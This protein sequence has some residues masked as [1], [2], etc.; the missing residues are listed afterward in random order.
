MKL[1]L[2]YTLGLFCLLLCSCQLQHLDV[3]NLTVEGRENFVGLQ[4]QQPR[5]SWKITAA[6]GKPITQTAYQIF[7]ASTKEGA[8][9]G[10]ATLWNSGKVTSDSSL[11]VLF[12]GQALASYAKV[13]WKVKVWTAQGDSAT[14]AVNEWSM[15]ILKKEEWKAKWI[16]LDTFS[17]GDAPRRQQTR[18]AARYL[19]KEVSISKTLSQATASISGLGLYELYI[20][21]EKIGDDVMSP[22]A[23]DYNHEVPYNTYNITK[24]LLKGNNAI[25]VVLGNGRFFNLRDFKGK[26][27]PVTGIPQINYGYPRMILQIRLVYTDGSIDY[28]QSDPS[29]KIT[30]QGPIRANNE[31][32][33]EEYDA[34]MELNGW[35]K[36]G[37]DDASWQQAAL[38]KPP[39]GKLY[40]QTNENIKIKQTLKPKSIYK[41]VKGTY[42][43]DMGQNMVGW[44]RIQVKG[45]T[46]DTVRMVFAERLKNKDT[47]YL[48][49]LRDA[50]VTDTYV[51][52]GST[53]EN[54]APRFT[55]HGFQ[56]IEVSGL[57]YQPTIADFQGEVVY[58]DVPTIGQF[59]TSDPTINQ[60][61]S[62]AY[63]SIRGNY[64]GIPTDC[65]QRDERVAWLG[66]R[67]MS[68]YGESFLFDNSRLYSKWMADT[69]SAQLAN[70]SLPDIVP[71]YW[72]NNSDNV[73]YPSAFI[74]IPEMLRKQFGDEKTYRSYYPY[75]KKWLMYMWK[76]HGKGDLV[77]KDSYGDWCVAPEEGTNTIWTNDP[78]RTTDGGLV[79]ASYYYYCLT[80]MENF[81]KL[82][83]LE[84]DLKQFAELK[85]RVYLAFNKKF[86]NATE[87]HYSNNTTTANLLPLTFG[88]VPAD[89]KQA[90]FQ[91]IVAR[92][93]A[94]G[95]HI[96]SGIMGMMW[97]MRGLSDHG[98]PDLAYKLATNTTYPSW[99]YM[100]ANGATT[101]W[102]LWNG[103][104]ADPL[105]N[106]WNHQMLL[107]DLLIWYYEY[108]AGIKSDPQATAFKKIIMNPIFPDSLKYVSAS[109]VSKY[110]TIKSHWSKDKE[111]FTWKI[112]VPPNSS[113]LVYLPA[114]D[115]RNVQEGDH[116]LASR[117]G[118]T[119][120]GQEK[121]CILIE[122]GSG[123]YDFTV[124][125]IDQK[126]TVTLY[127]KKL[128][129]KASYPELLLNESAHQLSPNGLAVTKANSLVKLN[130]YY[131]LASRL[132]RYH[133]RF[134]KDA[135]GI[136]QSDLGDFKATVD[137]PN[138]KIAIATN[139]ETATKADFLNA[140]HEYIVEI[141]R[142]YQESK[143]RIIDVNTGQSA[144][145]TATNDGPGGHGA[146]VVNKGFPVG[147][148]YDYYCFGL[149]SGTAM[150]V[151]ELEVLAKAADLH[152]LIYGDSITEPEGYFPTS[153]FPQSWTQLI[154]K[155][156][157]GKGISSGRGGT[158][159]RELLDRI[160]NELPYV[161]SKYVM[162]TIGTN[163][164][165]TAENL[166]ELVEYIQSQGSIP[167]LN[168][169][170]SNES[171][172][173]VA[174][175]AVIEKVRNKYKINGCKFDIATSVDKE[176]KQVD[177]STMW[178]EDYDFGKIYHHPN[179]K[180][181]LQM[182]NR[183][184]IDVPEIYK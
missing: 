90:V 40:A 140:A 59:N 46:G 127:H 34:R 51:L 53:K 113:A 66:D 122:I 181:S 159:I 37:Y 105:M 85:T 62:N 52:K 153:D 4:E 124:L 25:G 65:P 10:D 141:H 102:E 50:R 19:R 144:E 48:A 77:L 152:L 175:N 125:P 173:Q 145:I 68:S 80:L 147:R 12:K 128:N 28:I 8:E 101:I 121:G 33:G 169:I 126:P 182:Y 35:S 81:A 24:Q 3:Q 22:T 93:A 71:A 73:T 70:G 133:V 108:L 183:T 89:K 179:V 88:L 155:N 131:S 123:S 49:N 137:L 1:N 146:G 138:K 116:P 151:S 104:T 11:N 74:I 67:L 47:L 157:K 97:I 99:G 17:R 98:R 20:N 16:G 69:K 79:A 168:N 75:M 38:V 36:P 156:I 83:G 161:K 149:N 166:S 23:T 29:W 64:R 119:I 94:Y 6:K 56:Y 143:L 54:W 9:K 150:V 84:A 164:G 158:T 165:N 91:K 115:I 109:Y 110:G 118:L 120:K 57:K 111:K 72:I 139:P 86:F 160:K 172:S 171:G 95:N 174:I 134:S 21:G 107:G 26:P 27:N 135:V 5:L 87:G 100:A 136:F 170:P 163:G 18:L 130:Y 60:I 13:Y 41:T 96:N 176:G 31:Y 103:N 7:V 180:G 58:D 148:Q 14:S 42:I 32:D 177:K 178:F 184:H 45:Q 61:Y 78:T 167:I 39:L 112:T 129:N 106:S 132:I 114:T 63:W 162:V 43:L 142:F 117:D 2:T 154:L 76:T 55:Y 30:D 82:Q 92:T 44:L 15:A